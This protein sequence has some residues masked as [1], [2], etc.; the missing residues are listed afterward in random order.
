MDKQLRP[1]R[2]SRLFPLGIAKL[3]PVVTSGKNFSVVPSVVV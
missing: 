3:L 2:N 1:A